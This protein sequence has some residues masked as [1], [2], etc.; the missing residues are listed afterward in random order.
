M[1]HGHNTPIH[2]QNP[3][4]DIAQVDCD[5]SPP[6]LNSYE[7]K[8]DARVARIRQQEAYIEAK[9]AAERLLATVEQEKQQPRQR[10]VRQKF[11]IEPRETI[12]RSAKVDVCYKEPPLEPLL[13]QSRPTMK[14]KRKSHS[15][16][17]N[18]SELTIDD[19]TT[20]S[21]IMPDVSITSPDSPVMCTRE[22]CQALVVMTSFVTPSSS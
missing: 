3:S 4:T 19:T 6:V 8:R 20:W 2:Q 15:S 21:D 7:R 17:S 1:D 18:Q 14:G 22:C 10:K 5:P 13:R 12:P 9:Y 16:S 11:R